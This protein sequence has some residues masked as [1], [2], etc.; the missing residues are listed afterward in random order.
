MSSFFLYI[1]TLAHTY[2]QKEA[3]KRA[4]PATYMNTHSHMSVH[5]FR[6]NEH[7]HIHIHTYIQ[8]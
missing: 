8:A 7:I 5:V 1:Y 6:I 4:K 2:T 3:T